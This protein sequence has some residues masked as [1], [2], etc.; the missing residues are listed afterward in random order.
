[1]P[2]NAQGSTVAIGGTD[3]EYVVFGGG[4]KPLVVL[5][6]LSDGLRTVG[7]HQNMLARYFRQFAQMYRVYVFSRK[8]ALENGCTT[9]DMARDQRSAMEA[10]GIARAYVMGISQGGMIAQYL[11]I[12][13]PERV[14]KLV[15]AVTVSRQTETVR[16]VVGSWIR[17]AEANDYKGLIMDTMKKSFSDRY[18][19]KYRAVLPVVSRV[20]KPKDY[21]RFLIQADACMT[22][23]AFDELHKISCPVLVIGGDS[24]EVV[25]QN[26]SA[27]MAGQIPG[28]RLQ[29]YKGLGHGAYDETKDFYQQILRFLQT[30]EGS[31]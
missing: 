2:Y 9:R 28:S 20:G 21:R 1:M 27:E 18:M 14:E 7:K 23:N 30:D 25:G 19:R 29:I 4:E 3:M 26:A 15:L 10:L 22:H 24:D 12:D 5:P 6:G 8:N 17:M 31:A 13:D 16:R 11:A